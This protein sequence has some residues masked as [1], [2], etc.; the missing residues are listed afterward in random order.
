MAETVTAE[1][2]S[3]LRRWLR[4]EADVPVRVIV[5]NR[6]KVVVLDG[7]GNA[8]NEGGMAMFAGAELKL[9]DQIAVEFTPAYASPIRVEA[10]VCNRSGYVYGLEF[11]A[12]TSA[13]KTQVS[14]FRN[15]LKTV[16]GTV[17]N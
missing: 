2:A 10:R 4:F 1:S 16:T 7:R 15:H 9:G 11:L 13:R 17:E 12:D 3:T 14:T 6:H 8:L 5:T